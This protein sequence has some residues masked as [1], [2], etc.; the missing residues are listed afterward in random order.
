MDTNKEWSEANPVGSKVR[1]LCCE[2]QEMEVVTE[3]FFVPGQHCVLLKNGGHQL[4]VPLD[5][6]K[7]TRELFLPNDERVHPY[8]RRRTSTTGLRLKS[9]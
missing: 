9:G 8:Q 3:A 1:M 4:V 2:G 7:G 6:I 5:A